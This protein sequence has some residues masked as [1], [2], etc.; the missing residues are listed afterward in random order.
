MRSRGSV[1]RPNTVRGSSAHIPAPVIP[2]AQDILLCFKYLLL[3]TKFT[4]RGRDGIYFEQVLERFR[5]ICRARPG[6]LKGAKAW[7]CHPIEWSATSE[8]D[9][10]VGLPEHLQDEAPMQ[11]G[12]GR[13]R[14]RLQGFFAGIVFHV[15]WFDAEHALYPG[16]A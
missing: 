2:E 4:P 9:G 6:E 16:D 12:L 10:F 1:P 14:G 7:R 15:V 11:I 13:T 3:S 8:P 5:D